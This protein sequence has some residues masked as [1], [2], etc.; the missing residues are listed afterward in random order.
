MANAKIK[1]NGNTAVILESY[2]AT[3]LLKAPFKVILKDSVKQVVDSEGVVLETIIPDPDGLIKAVAQARVLHPHKLVG[4]ELKFLRTA[5]GLR[6]KD[7]A[8]A[9]AVSPEHMSRLEADDKVLSPQCEMLIRI[10]TYVSALPFTTKKEIVATQ[11][12][13]QVG[14]VFGGL[15]IRPCH[16]IDE[17]LEFVLVR[18]HRNPDIG[19]L[20]NDD[21]NGTW[22]EPIAA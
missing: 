8:N 9:I 1:W 11:V 22:D 21:S 15:S 6:S 20:D 18:K 12:A 13:K 4:P 19:S 10:Y 16:S 17:T 7:L 3:D 14:R 2:D 5:L